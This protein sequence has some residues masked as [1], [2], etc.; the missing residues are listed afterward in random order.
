[1]AR[2]RPTAAIPHIDGGSRALASR[3]TIVARLTPAMPAAIATLA[4]SG[5]QALGCVERFV[6]LSGAGLEV[7]S[8][9]YGVWGLAADGE[10]SVQNPTA[11]RRDT[12]EQVVLTR[13]EVEIVEVHCHGGAAVC[14]AL[15]ND[16]TSA[17]C[18]LV[19]SEQWPTR[20]SC[21]LARAAEVALL[22]ATTDRA[23]AV[24]LD[25]R[26]GALRQAIE[27]VARRFAAYELADCANASNTLEQ[28]LC[29]AD[30]G[31]HLSRPWK[32][33]LVG[34]PNVGKSSLLNAMAGTRQAIVH[35]APGTTRDWI[36][37]SSAID[38]W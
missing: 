32:I 11:D 35:H 2:R 9:R 25:Q 36:E 4:I 19:P 1:M 26:N 34:P 22:D 12:L 20:L 8:L 31:L 15:L 24:L 5:P 10:G 17:G 29:W 30:F 38:G 13:P 18:V 23:A 21:P 14:A 33:V 6:R 27:N 16:L 7:G 28:L 37:W 3:N